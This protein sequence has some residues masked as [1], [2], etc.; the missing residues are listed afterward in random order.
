MCQQVMADC[1]RLRALKVGVPG[2]HPP[3]MSTSLGGE[4]LD[5]YGDRGHQVR[6]RMPAVKPQVQ[7]DLVVARAARMKGGPSGSE[8][9]QAALDGR[10]DV[11]VGVAEIEF[12]C[13][14]LAPD[15]A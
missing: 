14:E 5:D 7:R 1:H 2:H 13:V 8:L 10:M 4:S 15:A 3:G 9:G 12:T 11:L 6:R